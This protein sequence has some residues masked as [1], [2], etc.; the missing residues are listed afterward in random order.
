MWPCAAGELEA[1]MLEGHAVQRILLT[2]ATERFMWRRPGEERLRMKAVGFG[3]HHPNQ[4]L[5]TSMSAVF[6][7]A[8]LLALSI[9]VAWAHGTSVTSSDPAAGATVT[10][11]PQRVTVRFDEELATHDS[12]LWVL[13]AAGRRVSTGNGAFDL[14]DADHQVMLAALPNALAEG[15]YTVKWHAVLTDGDASDGELQ[16]AVRAQP[17]AAGQRRKAWGE[18]LVALSALAIAA[19]VLV[20]RRRSAG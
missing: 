10:R 6:L 7:T 15:V 3:D 12:A 11:A 18:G 13:D 17:D 1:G 9:G 20:A 4:T 5:A 14:N 2:G 16:F 8:V 19:V